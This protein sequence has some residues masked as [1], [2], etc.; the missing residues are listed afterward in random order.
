MILLL[1]SASLVVGLSYSPVVTGVWYSTSSGDD[2]ISPLTLHPGSPLTLHLCCVSPVSR[3]G[4][5]CCLW[6]LQHWATR[7][8]VCQIRWWISESPLFPH[9]LHV[10][11][12]CMVTVT[13]FPSLT[14]NFHPFASQ[15]CSSLKL[16]L[17]SFNFSKLFYSKNEDIAVMLTLLFTVFV[18]PAQTGKCV[19]SSPPTQ[20][21]F[22]LSH[23]SFIAG[24]LSTAALTWTTCLTS[25]RGMA[26]CSCS[27]AWTERSLHGTIFQWLPLNYV[28]PEEAKAVCR[29]VCRK[30]SITEMEAMCRTIWKKHV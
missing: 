15:A 1:R 14:V 22:A 2:D 10:T 30:M 13:T 8:F 23:L 25:I 9:P 24:T 7:C 5:N 17:R 18:V 26:P 20:S 28:S 11:P 16:L 4:C 3:C 27:K 6:N 29:D 21:I 19:W 12:R